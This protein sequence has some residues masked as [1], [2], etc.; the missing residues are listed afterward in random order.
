LLGAAVL[1][2]ALAGPTGPAAAQATFNL[3]GDTATV[4]VTSLRDMPFRTVV[5]QQYD[6]SCG[7]AAVATLMKHHYG[8]DVG[9][10]AIFQ[11]MY[12]QGDQAKIRK[13]GFSLLDMKTYLA[14]QG[15]HGEGYRWTPADLQRSTSPAIAL[16][17]VGPYRHFVLIKGVRGGK[18]M[19]GDPAQGLKL[20]PLPEFARIW[21]GVVLVAEPKTGPRAAYDRQEEWSHFT[22]GPI[23]PLNDTALASFTRDMPPFFQVVRFSNGGGAIR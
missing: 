22:L 1:V 21:N 14:S 6:Y 15:L 9:E 23:E 19:V 11:A 2:A 5:R 7:S 13:V 17:Q 20:F 12:A 18:V 16:I 4:R 3:I 10:A 8:R